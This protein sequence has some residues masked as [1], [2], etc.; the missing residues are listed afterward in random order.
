MLLDPS[1]SLPVAPLLRAPG[2]LSQQRR[3]ISRG[4][5]GPPVGA[6]DAGAS[7]GLPVAP[8]YE[9]QNDPNILRTDPLLRSFW[10]YLSPRCSPSVR[11]GRVLVDL[12]AVAAA[13]RR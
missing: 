1:D 10:R 8:G 12:V 7:K 11:I 6:R 5:S 2:M 3:L 13:T 4:R 9:G